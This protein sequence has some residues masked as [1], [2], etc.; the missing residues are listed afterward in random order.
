MSPFCIMTTTRL[1]SAGIA[2]STTMVLPLGMVGS[3]ESP[4]IRNANV[5][6]LWL[7]IAGIHSSAS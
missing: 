3:I 2:G 7:P 5:W 6:A 1:L 4:L